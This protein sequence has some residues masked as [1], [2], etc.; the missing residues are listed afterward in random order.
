VQASFG[1]SSFRLTLGV[2]GRGVTRAPGLA[3]SC[4]RR[5]S[6]AVDADAVVRIRATP[7]RGWRF[8]RWSGACGGRG[9][10]AV[11]MSAARTVTAVFQRTRRR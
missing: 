1:P 5:C 10:C 6:T 4:A 8:L 9:A 7:T 2:V 3:F 11:R